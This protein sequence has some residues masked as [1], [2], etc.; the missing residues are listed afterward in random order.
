MS[1]SEQVTGAATADNVASD[2][3]Q[4]HEA[5]IRDFYLT[6]RKTLRQVKEEMEKCGFP[7]KPLS[8]W[9]TKL[10]DH[11]K[12]PG[13]FHNGILPRLLGAWKSVEWWNIVPVGRAFS[14]QEVE[15]FRSHLDVVPTGSQSF[16]RPSHDL[17]YRLVTSRGNISLNEFISTSIYLLSN[18]LHDPDDGDK[19]LHILCSLV[20]HDPQLFAQLLQCELPT[21]RATWQSLFTYS[22]SHQHKLVFGILQDIGMRFVWLNPSDAGVLVSA[23]AMDFPTNVIV[24]IIDYL[25]RAGENNHFWRD[26]LDAISISYGKG[27]LEIANTL[28]QTFDINAPMSNKPMC[29][30]WEDRRRPRRFQNLPVSI[31]LGLVLSFDN[32]KVGH[33]NLLDFLTSSGADVDKVLPWQWYA[34]KPSQKWYNKNEVNRALRPTILDHAF[35]LERCLFDRLSQ[36]SKASKSRLTKTGLV[37]SLEKG[38]DAFNDYLRSRVLA[39]RSFD[40]K[41][42]HSIMEFLLLDQFKAAQWN[43]WVTEIYPSHLRRLARVREMDVNVVRSSIQYGVELNTGSDSLPDI[44][45]VLGRVLKQLRTEVAEDPLKLLHLLISKGANINE[46]NLEQAVETEG[47]TFLKWLQ[48]MVK[49]FPAKAAGALAK[50]ALLNNFEAVQFLLG[51]G[52]DPHTFINSTTA[53]LLEPRDIVIKDVTGATLEKLY[54]VQAIAAGVGRGPIFKYSSLKMIQFLAESGAHLAV[55][56]NDS[57]PFAFLVLLL[58]NGGGLYGE[59]GDPEL[60]EKTEFVVGALKQSKHWSNPPAYLLELCIRSWGNIPADDSEERLKIF[61]YLLD[62][63]AVVNPGSPLAALTRFGGNKQLLSRVLRS[64]AD[65]NAYT[66]VSH[67]DFVSNFTATPLQA[68][69][70]L[71]NQDLVQLF[72]DLG[73][74]VNSPASSR[75]GKT[76]LQAICQWDPATQEEHHR[77]MMICHLLLSR[78]ADVNAAP[79]SRSGETA[80]QGAVVQGDIELTA[81]LIRSGAHVNAPPPKYAFGCALDWAAHYGRLDICKLLLEAN[82][83]SHDRGMTGYDGAINEAQSQGHYAVASVIRDHLMHVREQNLDGPEFQEVAEDYH[84]SYGYNKDDESTDDDYWN[85]FDSYY[86]Y[87]EKDDHS[88]DEESSECESVE[89]HSTNASVGQLPI[90]RADPPGDPQGITAMQA[91]DNFLTH[92]FVGYTGPGIDLSMGDLNFEWGHAPLPN[93]FMGPLTDVSHVQ[94]FPELQLAPNAPANDWLTHTGTGFGFPPGD[95]QLAGNEW[96][97]QN[98]FG[99]WAG[100]PDDSTLWPQW[101]GMQDVDFGMGVFNMQ[102]ADFGFGI[103]D[104]NRQPPPTYPLGEPV[105]EDLDAEEQ[106]FLNVL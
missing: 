105:I 34:W 106:E 40:R 68:A 17:G 98:A 7:T 97:P 47:F 43:V 14:A 15:V 19:G 58:E 54:S 18:Q 16:P 38:L 10:R 92:D 33:W 53:S 99:A 101:I 90:A 67:R 93:Y 39:T 25:R 6:K 95:M 42:M 89:E 30:Y 85:E 3:W 103:L 71:G 8:T 49:D 13:V 27:R 74:N 59:S 9:E 20:Q 100:M 36:Y 55:G 37:L 66:A 41:A 32:T 91:F 23:L 81:I 57:T 72:V 86:E 52:V 80:L 11:L 56:P 28:V 60:F 88:T 44:N 1:T 84:T 46:E 62:Q 104:S 69:A 76:A 77:K 22:Q 79:A 83:L 75:Q 87:N 63:G 82:A 21:G 64:G 78:G 96:M 2:I 48:P 51:S 31:F 26:I 5:Q 61:E 24:S 4:Q 94:V 35:R 73:A 45:S 50:A 102:D 65:I 70:F 29:V 12:I